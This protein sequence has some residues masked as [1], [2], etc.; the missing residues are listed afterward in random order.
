MPAKE[1]KTEADKT[2]AMQM[3]DKYASVP[4]SICHAHRVYC[5]CLPAVAGVTAEDGWVLH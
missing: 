3:P 1:V 4:V 5:R 2:G